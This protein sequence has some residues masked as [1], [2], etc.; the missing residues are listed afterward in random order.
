MLEIGAEPSRRR[1]SMV[2]GKRSLTCD[3]EELPVDP[4]E[5][6]GR[7]SRIEIVAAEL[8]LEGVGQGSGEASHDL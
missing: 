7:D 2:S 5:Q 4:D 6:A 1:R 8:L 3:D